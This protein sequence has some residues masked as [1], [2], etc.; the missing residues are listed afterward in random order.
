MILLIK[1]YNVFGYLKVEKG[2]YCFVCIL[3]FDLVKCC[4]IFFCLVDVM[5]EFDEM[6]D[7]EINLDDLKIDIYWVSGVGG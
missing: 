2:V 7:I 1:G 4:Y 5:L 3:F 6:I